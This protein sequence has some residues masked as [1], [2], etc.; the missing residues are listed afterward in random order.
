MRR[1]AA[2]DGGLDVPG[3]AAHHSRTAARAFG[4][5]RTEYAARYTY[6]IG[7]DG[8][9]LFVDRDVKPAT[10]GED[11]ARRL[12]GLKIPRREKASRN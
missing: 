6:Y 8:T 7:K 3:P 12:A 4:V 2:L 9:I 11:I 5:L 10:A 1:L